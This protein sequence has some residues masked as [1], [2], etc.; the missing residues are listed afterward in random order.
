MVTPPAS[1]SASFVEL[2]PSPPPPVVGFVV[3]PPEPVVNVGMPPVPPVPAVP[4]R[5]P[6]PRSSS[7]SRS[8]MPVIELH[9]PSAALEAMKRKKAFRERP[10]DRIGDLICH[11]AA[12][13]GPG[14]AHK[15]DVG[16]IEDPYPKASVRR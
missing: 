16:E 13:Q 10:V 9:A 3:M 7:S 4:P 15:K 6:P 14:A 1:E 8:L 12:C 5:A 2:P 11:H